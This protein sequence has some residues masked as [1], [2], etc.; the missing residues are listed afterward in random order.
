MQIQFEFGLHK[1]KTAEGI[2]LITSGHCLDK[3]TVYLNQYTKYV[4]EQTITHEV[5]H[6]LLRQMQVPDT[7]HHFAI[8]QI[9][10]T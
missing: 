3:P 9:L 10:Y 7:F 4:V 5:L 2:E 6:Y 8:K 1:K